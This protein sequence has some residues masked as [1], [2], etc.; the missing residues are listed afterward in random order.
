MIHEV[1]LDRIAE[2]SYFFRLSDYS[3]ALLELYES[4]EGFIR[5]EAR[6]NEVISFVRGGL[7]D[8][9]ISRMRSSVAWGIPVPDDPD[10]TVY[11]WLDALTNYITAIGYGNEER[12]RAVGFEKFWPAV[13]LVGKDILR[14]HAVY[15]PA[16]LMAANLPV[17]RTVFAHGMLLDATGRK[18][19]KTL[20]NAVDLNILHR[21][22]PDTDVIRYFCLREVAFG[23]DAKFSYELIIDRANAD[24]AGGLG[25]LSSRTLTM[26]DRYCAGRIPAA[27][28][29]EEQYLAAKR[30][31]IDPDDQAFATALEHARDQSIGFFEDYAFNRAVEAAWSILSRAD[32]MISDAK[33][34]DLAKTEAQ[35]G[36]LELVLYRAAEALRWLAVLLH[37]VMPEATGAI[38][39]QLGQTTDLSKI[40]PGTLQWAA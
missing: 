37:P 24:L 4:G 39:R 21:H 13:H 26:I 1:A 5:P 30:A 23:Q 34:W 25:N 12:E 18:M 17:P 31:N 19:S 15:W 27:I 6:R 32:K 11:V 36:T 38:W 40:D 29:P 7:Q 14:F 20:G 35:R 33:P 2:E 22:F 3:E 9:S 28:L 8:L 10:H 16:F